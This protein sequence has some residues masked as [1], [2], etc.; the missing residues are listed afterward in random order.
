MMRL[1]LL[2][3]LWLAGCSTGEPVPELPEPVVAS[4]SLR[5]APVQPVAPPA[6]TARL[7]VDAAA[8]QQRVKE[9]IAP[10]SAPLAAV[11][12]LEPLTRRVNRALAVLE[13]HRTKRGY[14]P[15]DVRA[16]RAAADA[17]ALFLDSQAEVPPVEV[18]RS[19]P[20]NPEPLPTS[21]PEAKP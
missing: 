12:T 10:P 16:A 21:E 20:P 9:F 7:K 8:V 14:R 19:G 1:V 6:V 15:A 13:L 4:P 3:A 5:T 2:L 11:A 18:P 17:V